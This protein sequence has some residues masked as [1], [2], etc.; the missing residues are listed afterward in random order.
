MDKEIKS[1]LIL[2]YIEIKM[3]MYNLIRRITRQLP[4]LTQLE[5]QYVSPKVN[6]LNL[7]KTLS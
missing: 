4:Q 7:Y 6:C 1:L 2:Y 3:L 5:L